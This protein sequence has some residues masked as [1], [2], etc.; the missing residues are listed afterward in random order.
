MFRK[1]YDSQSNPNEMLDSLTRYQ[2]GAGINTRIYAERAGTGGGR[3]VGN[4]ID[5]EA[6]RPSRSSPSSDS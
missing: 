5:I 2:V 6:I 4:I 3:C 1:D